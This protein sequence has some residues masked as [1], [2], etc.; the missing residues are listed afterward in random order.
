MPLYA[1]P[2]NHLTMKKDGIAIPES[3]LAAVSPFDFS[4]RK[5]GWYRTYF[6]W[7]EKGD[8]EMSILIEDFAPQWIKK[9]NRKMRTMDRALNESNKKS[10]LGCRAVTEERRARKEKAKLE[11]AVGGF[12]VS[13]VW[14]IWYSY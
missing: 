12:A 13:C 7:S 6:E 5:K 3:A 9:I 11:K 8:V 2:W 1:C 4:Y 14:G 10:Y